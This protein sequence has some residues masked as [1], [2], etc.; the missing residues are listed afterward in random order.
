MGFALPRIYWVLIAFDAIILGLFP[1]LAKLFPME[2]LPVNKNKTAQD[3]TLAG[4]FHLTLIVGLVT[5]GS[6]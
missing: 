2:A 5:L 4:P 6:S 1:F 3:K